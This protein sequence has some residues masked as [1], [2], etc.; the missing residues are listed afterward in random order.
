MLLPTTTTVEIG[1]EDYQRLLEL[2]KT[3]GETVQAVLSKAID[4]YHRQLFLTQL[5]QDFAE[6]RKNPELWEEELAERRAW[7][8]TLLDGIEDE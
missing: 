2:S 5:S 1:T 4:E 8:V 3:A 6:L 7:D